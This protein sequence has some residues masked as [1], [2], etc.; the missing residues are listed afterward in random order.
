[1]NVC[2]LYLT[3][4]SVINSG[5]DNKVIGKCKEL[6]KIFP[7][8]ACVRISNY[9]TEGG[10]DFFSQYDFEYSQQK[11]FG[12][13]H[14]KKALFKAVSDFI[15]QNENKFD[16]FITR[17]PFADY[18]LLELV[19]RHAGKIVFEHNT[20]ELEERRLVA[21]NNRLKIPFSFR[22]SVIAYYIE[23]VFFES[24]IE[25][26]IGSKCLQYAAGGIVVTPEI[27]KIVK[28]RYKNYKTIVI[29]NGIAME[30]K[31][32]IARKKQGS[33][34]NGVFLAGT[35][36]DWHGIERIIE[37]FCSS[38]VQDKMHLYFV[39]RIEKKIKEGVREKFRKSIHFIDYL[40]KK[41]LHTFLDDMHFAV[42][43][44]ALHKAGL[45]EGSVLKV[46]EYLAAGL[47]L[48]LGHVDPHLK[49]IPELDRYC[50]HFPADDSLMDF[51]L[52]YK[53]ISR[54]YDENE[55]LNVKIHELA[56]E[57]LA[58]SE[59]LKPLTQFLYTIHN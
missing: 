2:Y 59:V 38:Y 31:M 37:S 11:Y 45:N 36:A 40:D 20:N 44:C 23:A 29:P 1:M 19:K 47:P 49:T 3:P 15:T 9:E 8:M 27:E 10:I 35:Y 34:M 46:R 48:V 22:P 39:G 18:S 13:Y 42:G 50:I 6:K 25:R 52:V 56:N 24:Y 4:Y 57:H 58:W 21:R 16:L 30:S 28:S 53:E 12:L 17:Y 5:V 32:L 43:S 14:F 7:G 54:F 55:I 51:D 26:T 33:V 41:D